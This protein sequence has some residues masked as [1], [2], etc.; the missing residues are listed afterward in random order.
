MKEKTLYYISQALD[1]LS[2]K[3]LYLSF[4]WCP[5]INDK[6]LENFSY[7]LKSAKSLQE[8]DLVFPS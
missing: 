2:L 6:A 8:I 4:A 1:A 3:K 7:G 5:E